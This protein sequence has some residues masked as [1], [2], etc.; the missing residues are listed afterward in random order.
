MM[1]SAV[2]VYVYVGKMESNRSYCYLELAPTQDTSPSQQQVGGCRAQLYRKGNEHCN[3]TPS[4]GL[5]VLVT[6]MR[7]RRLPTSPE[8]KARI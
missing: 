7:G 5:Q 8:A 3:E 1:P 2:C 6:S 4:P